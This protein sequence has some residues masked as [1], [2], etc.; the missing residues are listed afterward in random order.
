MD[1]LENEFELTFVKPILGLLI[2]S[3]RLLRLLRCWWRANGIEEVTL[4]KL[5]YRDEHND[6]VSN[7]IRQQYPQD[8]YTNN[9]DSKNSNTH[10]SR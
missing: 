10:L 5:F 1:D 8:V 7:D 6:N 9:N 3:H 4:H 2:D